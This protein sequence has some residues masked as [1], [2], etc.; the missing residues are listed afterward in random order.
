MFVLVAYQFA[1]GVTQARMEQVLKKV[2]FVQN[3]FALLVLSFKKNCKFLMCNLMKMFYQ[4][5]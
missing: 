1:L 2:T 3:V 5:K 4:V